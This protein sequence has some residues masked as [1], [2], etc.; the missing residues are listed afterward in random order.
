MP[1]TKKTTAKKG[2]TSPS[3]KKKKTHV[4]TERTTMAF[5]RTKRT[6]TLILLW[7]LVIAYAVCY[8]VFVY[9]KDLRLLAP[10]VA[11]KLSNH[12]FLSIETVERMAALLLGRIGRNAKAPDLQLRADYTSF[13]QVM[14]VMHNRADLWRNLVAIAMFVS[15]ASSLILHLIWRVRSNRIISPSREVPV[16]RNRYYDL[17]VICVVINCLLAAVLH[18]LGY[19]GQQDVPFRQLAYNGVFV[20]SPLAMILSTRLTAPMCVSGNS[21]YFV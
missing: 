20:L 13:Q 8:L 1:A 2:T 9:Q 15:I 16:V 14:N 7:L 19:A 10:D 6:A 21:C 5:R 18:R 17:L 11:A 3:V 4:R 12:S